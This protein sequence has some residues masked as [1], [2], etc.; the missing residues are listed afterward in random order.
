MVFEK[1]SLN[2]RLSLNLMS[3]NRDCTVFPK[4]V[5]ERLET[6]EKLDFSF[7]NFGSVAN[8]SLIATFGGA[9]I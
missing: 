8:A 1:K 2:H 9:R 5:K 3:L 6:A 4:V 7:F